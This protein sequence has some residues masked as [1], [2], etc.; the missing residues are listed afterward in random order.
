[1]FIRN[2]ADYGLRPKKRIY[3][4]KRPDGHCAQQKV[5]VINREDGV[6]SVVLRRSRQRLQGGR[7]LQYHDLLLHDPADGNVSEFLYSDALTE[8]LISRDGRFS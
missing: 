7:R 4:P 2:V 1:M 6:M 3:L 8:V 5:I